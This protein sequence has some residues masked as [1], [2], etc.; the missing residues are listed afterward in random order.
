ML[1]RKTKK[2]KRNWAVAP[3]LIGLLWIST[4]ALWHSVSTPSF[5]AETEDPVWV[6]VTGVANVTEYLTSLVLYSTDPQSKTAVV[7]KYDAD[8]NGLVVEW[9]VNADALSVGSGNIIN[10]TW[11]AILWWEKNEI[12][13]EN[14]NYYVILWWKKNLVTINAKLTWNV[15]VGWSGAKFDWS[16]WTNSYSLIIWWD[17]AWYAWS[18]QVYLWWSWSR[19]SFS[20]N[21]TLSLWTWGNI[22]SAGSVL[23]WEKIKWWVAGNNLSKY[24]NIFVWSDTD[25]FS[26]NVSWA[27]YVN[28]QSGFW[29]NTNNPR[30]T[31]DMKNAGV[32]VIEKNT[33]LSSATLVDCKED[34]KGTIVY[35]SRTSWTTNVAW[36][37]GCNGSGWVPFSI[38]PNIQSVCNKNASTLKCLGTVTNV[39]K[40]SVNWVMRWYSDANDGN[41]DWFYP[42]WTYGGVENVD[43][44]DRECSYTC[45]CNKTGKCYH[46]NVENPIGWFTWSCVECT[47]IENKQEWILSWDGVDNCSFN[48]K[49]WYKYNEHDRTCTTCLVGE[50]TP[51]KN[52]SGSCDRCAMPLWIVLKSNWTVDSAWT[53]TVWILKDGTPYFWDF[54]T[55]WKWWNKYT[56]DFTCAPW[57]RI[58]DSNN[59]NNSCIM[60]KNWEYSD[61]T[62]TSC[63]R[64][65]NKPE[66]ITFRWKNYMVEHYPE[67]TQWNEGS[68][69][70]TTIIN[71]TS[72]WSWPE[73]CERE[74]KSEYWF[75]SEWDSCV[76]ADKNN[77]H[78]EV[79][80][81]ETKCVPNVKNRVCWTPSEWNP[82]STT[83][84]WSNIAY[85]RWWRWTWDSWEW[86]GV[87]W[88][89]V[90][91]STYV[92]RG[93][94]LSAC[95][96]TCPEDYTRNGNTCLA[97]E[98]W[99]CSSL[100]E[101]YV[102]NNNLASY[103]ASSLCNSSFWVLTAPTKEKS[104]L[105]YNSQWVFGWSPNAV[106][107][108]EWWEWWCKWEQD[109]L[110]VHCVAYVKWTAEPWKCGT[111][112]SAPSCVLKVITSRWITVDLHKP[113]LTWY[114]QY[115]E[116]TDRPWTQWSTNKWIKWQ[117]PWFYWWDFV[118]CGI[119]DNGYTFNGYSTGDQKCYSNTRIND[120]FKWDNWLTLSSLNSSWYIYWTWKFT[121]RLNTGTFTYEPETK[122]SYT[123]D[124]VI[125]NWWWNSTCKYTCATWYTVDSNNK[126]IANPY[127]IEYYLD[128][129]YKWASNHVY[130]TQKSLTS[131]SSLWISKSWY[132]F[133][134]WATSDKSLTRVYTDWQ[135][136]LNLTTVKDWTIKLYAIM[137]RTAYFYAYTNNTSYQYNNNE[138]CS[139]NK[140]EI[141][142]DRPGW[143]FWWWRT[144]T[145]AATSTLAIGNTLAWYCWD[146]FYAVYSRT[147]NFYS[148]ISWTKK[149]STQYY[150]S[151]NNYYVSVPSGFP[152]AVTSWTTL[153]WRWN[154]VASSADYSY[155]STYLTSSAQNFYS[156]YRRTVTLQ[157]NWN[158]WSWTGPTPSEQYQYF[159]STWA[160]SSVSFTLASNSYTRDWYVFSGWDLWGA[161]TTHT[162]SPWVSASAT[163]T[164]KAQWKTQGYSISYSLGWWTNDASNPSSYDVQTE[165]ITL[166]DPTR[167]WYTFKWWTRSNWTTPQ[168]GVKI[169]KWSTWNKSYTAN[170]E[171]VN[172]TISYDL[173]WGSVS[174]TNKTS[175]TIET[176]T[177][178]LNNPTRSFS[179]FKWWTG[180]NWTTPQT[181]VK[182]TKW[183]TWNKSYTA[184][185]DCVG[186]YVPSWN[187]CVEQEKNYVL[188]E[189]KLANRTVASHAGVSPSESVR[190]CANWG[191]MQDYLRGIRDCGA[192]CP[193]IWWNEDCLIDCGYVVS[194]TSD[195]F[196]CNNDAWNFMVTPCNTTD[197]AA[198]CSEHPWNK[199]YISIEDDFCDSW[200]IRTEQMLCGN[201]SALP[202]SGY[203][204][205]ITSCKSTVTYIN[206]NS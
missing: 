85:N 200:V 32:L 105:T 120:C 1:S 184:N 154:A 170:W 175:Y 27:F 101:T 97:P 131:A 142:T 188:Y 89:Y 3:L 204:D 58:S 10:G 185:W 134:G 52:Q 8:L 107:A 20:D 126:C 145:S 155:S 106:E 116:W 81:T 86:A 174:S 43:G 79:V 4:F 118:H 191:T 187:S 53:S 153:W 6:V 75:V 65:V 100:N 61:G 137:R 44:W 50:R 198:Y 70:N 176:S 13:S 67:E 12:K 55:V 161:W 77:T 102:G 72:N 123:S 62:A 159:N 26:P 33:S 122:W 19:N 195:F 117:C 29:L 183:S 127:K 37:C 160:V 11:S 63:S 133:Y 169:T 78:L 121:Q 25:S 129:N 30:M 76:C 57:F 14:A 158:W 166:K 103:S 73:S 9:A 104:I 99:E 203:T 15:I 173:K 92:S 31:F 21:Y 178:T 157:Y 146:N 196:E 42:Y 108:K 83:I 206:C 80:W 124:T 156:V 147:A 152:S 74:C 162:W 41:G 36:I 132:T 138:N 205:E 95:E 128:G 38:D 181:S 93:Y 51:A 54:T 69:S 143:T 49:G 150:N 125:Q 18:F 60:C 90:D 140:P 109:Y 193:S 24:T 189:N 35:I 144:D 192:G 22:V 148:W 17:N 23:M 111:S 114:T 179:T 199:C 113:V 164:A 201:C 82:D 28:A 96:W 197:Y 7:L 180:S 139:V 167:N 34:S 172:Y 2:S 190:V 165:T 16:L 84:T 186:W 56:C 112:T 94:V 151:N 141:T 177:F 168:K 64:C 71:Y 87:K 66:W 115:W 119:C 59:S 130:N 39:D 149:T 135:P 68:L 182:I 45:K 47:D 91:Y 40:W 46:P 48:C 110:D 171:A 163:I 88:S 202:D 98:P 5:A 136:V 194:W